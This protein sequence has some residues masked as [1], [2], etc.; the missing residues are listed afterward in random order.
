MRIDPFMQTQLFTFIFSVAL[1]DLR[2]SVVINKFFK[3]LSHIEHG[4]TRRSKRDDYNS[5]YFQAQLFPFIFS[6]ALS[7]LRVSVVINQVFKPR[8]H[9]EHGGSR[10]GRRDDYNSSYFQAQ[11]FPFIF[12]VVIKTEGCREVDERMEC[13]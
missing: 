1:S 8:R 9:L 10:R 5:S 4:G 13:Q 2:V 6:V 12:S 11:L 3:P 7:D